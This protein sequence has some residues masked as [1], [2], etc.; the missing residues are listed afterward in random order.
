MLAIVTGKKTTDPTDRSPSMRPFKRWLATV[1]LAVGLAVAVLGA[2]NQAGAAVDPYSMGKGEWI[3]VLSSAKSNLGVSTNDQLMSSLKAK[4]IKWVAVKCGDY[5]TWWTQFDSSLITAAH[6]QGILIFGYQRVG[7]TALTNEINI[8][9]QC[10]ATAA[11][12]YI[13]DAEVEFNGKNTQATQMMQGLRASYPNAFI[14]HAPLPYI[15]YHTTFPYVEFGSQCNAVMPQCYWKDIGVTPTQ[16][17]ADLDTQWKKWQ[18][19]WTGQGNRAAVKPIVPIGQGYNSVPSTEITTFV[20]ALKN[21][22]SPA[23]C[24]GPY[25]GV[26]FWSVQHH[27]SAVWSAIS[28]ATIGGSN[29]ILYDHGAAGYTETGTWTSSTSAGYYGA[30]ARYA[31]IGG[32]HTATWTP[33]LATA[34][35]YDVYAWW[36]AGTNRATSARY[37]VTHAA[38]SSDVNLN[39]TGGG[40]GWNF[41]GS[42]QFNAGSAG[43]IQLKAAQSTGNSVVIADA[44]RLVY[45][46]PAEVI[47]DNTASG[48]TASTNWTTSTAVAG[49]YGTN[50][51]QRATASVSDL[52]KWSAALPAT[53]N[54]KVYARWTAAADRSTTAPFSVVHSAGTTSVSVNQ[55]ANGGAWVLLGTFNFAAGTAERVRLSCWT[56]AG[57]NVIA[58]AVRFVPE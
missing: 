7:G 16:M 51:R 9:K 45:K 15:D 2:P 14:A 32:A 11:D 44:M 17:V 18:T 6:N 24:L 13:V 27:T 53:G 30:N 38:G 37:T 31:S 34:G 52:A 10:L 50:Y 46:G 22:A 55:Q 56:T 19:T 40:G 41:L 23:N 8:G 33:T 28:A 5:G 47:V 43:T 39:Q 21:D 29:G 26:S 25:Q 12:G 58:D 36:T 35:Y 42:F 48:F 1:P 54:Y 20:N 4:G 3:Y 49:Y 57:Y